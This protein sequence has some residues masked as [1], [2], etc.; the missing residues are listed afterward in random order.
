MQDYLRSRSQDL[1]HK[2]VVQLNTD[3]RNIKEAEA[4]LEFRD[5]F[6]KIIQLW[7]CEY[8]KQWIIDRK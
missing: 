7:I 5:M 6:L 8:E 1:L 4:Q 3:A 2:Y